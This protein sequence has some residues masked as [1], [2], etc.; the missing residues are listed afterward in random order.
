M[1]EILAQVAAR[2]TLADGIAEL[3]KFR[4]ISRI[5][6]SAGQLLIPDIQ[7]LT[8]KQ[9]LQQHEKKRIREFTDPLHQ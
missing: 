3:V 2:M 4:K 5:F 7:T 9:Q 8:D 6:K 1:V